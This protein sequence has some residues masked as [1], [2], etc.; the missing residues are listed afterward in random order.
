MAAT[1][2]SAR[3]PALDG[4]RVR[5]RALGPLV[6]L[7]ACAALAAPDAAQAQANPADML[8]YM[9]TELVHS[10]YTQAQVEGFLAELHEYDIG[11]ALLEMPRF[12]HKGTLKLPASNRQMLGVWASAAAAYGA[13]TG[14]DMNVTAVFNAIPKARGLSLEV[15]AT[16][17]NMVAAVE[18]TLATGVTGVQLDIEPYPTG[19][20]FIALLE[21]LDASFAR[22]GFHGRLSV[23]APG[24]T[25]TWTPAY[26]QRVAALVNQVDPTFYDSESTRV[27]GYQAWVGQG[28]AYYTANVPAATLVIPVIPCYAADAWHDPEVENIAAATGAL[29]AGLAAGS[30]VNGAGIWWWYAFFY[31]DGGRFKSAAD[32]AAWLAGTVALPFSS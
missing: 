11:Q 14:S 31:E 13:E 24:D 6:A 27:A 32:R 9:P 21:E 1:R 4:R 22:L 8:T 18:S 23:V 2:R 28:L 19:P 10:I 20:G 17:A 30:R 29:E 25:G 16:R 5:R 3:A 12:K 26:L 15:P 7:L